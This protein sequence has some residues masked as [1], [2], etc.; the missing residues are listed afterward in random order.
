MRK[1]I[2]VF[3]AIAMVFALS[4]SVSAYTINTDDA[5]IGAGDIFGTP[6]V[7]FEDAVVE[8]GKE[9]TVDLMIENNEGFTELKITVSADAGIAVASVANGDLAAASY[10]DSV[11]TVSASESVDLDGCIAK[12]TFVASAEG[13]KNVNLTATGK[14]GSANIVA[15]GSDCKITVEAAQGILGDVDDDGD[16]D[17]TDLGELKLYLAGYDKQLARGA[18]MNEDGSINTSDLSLLKLKLSGQ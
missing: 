5:Q 4:L 16:V 7:Y 3:L 1:F 13:V 10:A 17:A 11:I 6:A 14:D 9:V 8:N 18:D 2:S 12:V 15:L